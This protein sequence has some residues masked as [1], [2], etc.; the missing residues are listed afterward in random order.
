MK[1]RRSFK[2]AALAASL[3][4]LLAIPLIGVSPCG[5][6]FP[7]EHIVLGRIDAQQMRAHLG[8]EAACQVSKP[9]PDSTRHSSILSYVSAHS[10]TFSTM[11]LIV[12]VPTALFFLLLAKRDELRLSLRSQFP[13]G[14]VFAPLAP[15]PE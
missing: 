11:M 1:A 6:R 14:R 8:Q 12:W 4:W 7:H 5:I 15:P 13:A 9:Q 3:V 10:V 2:V